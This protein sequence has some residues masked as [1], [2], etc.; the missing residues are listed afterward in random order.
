LVAGAAV[1]RARHAAET[2]AAR[3]EVMV[4]ALADVDRMQEAVELLCTVWGSDPRDPPIRREMV[5]ALAHAGNYVAGATTEGRLI[6]V[7]VGFLGNHQ[8]QPVLHSHILGVAGDMQGRSVGF[9]LKQHQRWWSLAHGLEHV[10]WT[11]DPLVRRNGNFNVNKLGARIVAYHPNFY[12]PMDDGINSGDETDRCVVWWPLLDEHVVRT[13]EGGQSEPRGD[14]PPGCP[15][16]LE[17]DAGGW[18]HLS[19]EV[20]AGGPGG[21]SRLAVWVPGDVV[22]MRRADPEKALAWRRALRTALSG[23]LAAGHSVRGVTRSGWYVL[24]REGGRRR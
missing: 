21:A 8:G 18:P 24:E 1:T 11:F 17:A 4:D 16:V 15:V 22:G 3:A 7:A 23:A 10:T 19:G 12:G 6:G 5:K 2:A 20:G 14:P 13:A 9:A